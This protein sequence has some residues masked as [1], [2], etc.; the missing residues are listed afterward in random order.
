MQTKKAVFLATSLLA[1]V[2]GSLATQ[3]QLLWTVGQKDGAWP[4]G[5][6]GGAKATFVQENGS[7]NELP[8]DPASPETNGQ[9]DN[10]Y[11]LAGTY[12]TMIESVGALYGDYTPVGTVAANEEA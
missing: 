1:L 11:Y 12:T 8:G 4:V 5:D 10:D 6:G 9:A 7:I 3:A 2:A